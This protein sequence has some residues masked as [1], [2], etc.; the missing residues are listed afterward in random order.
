MNNTELISQ[1]NA[2]IKMWRGNIEA[3]EATGCDEIELETADHERLIAVLKAAA[4]ALEAA[5]LS[6]E[7]IGWVFEEAERPEGDVR[8]RNWVEK[9]S[10]HKPAV[11]WMQRNVQAVYT[12]PAPQVPMT[13]YKALYEDLLHQVSQKFKDETRHQTAK[14]Y[15]ASWE[16]RSVRSEPAKSAHHKIGVK[17]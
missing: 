12:H 4:N 7:P 10:R 11:P 6:S 16:G 14:R 9:F 2:E 3:L 15:I 1:I 17:S 8:G 13:D 5:Q